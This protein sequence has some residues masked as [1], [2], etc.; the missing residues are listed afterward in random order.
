MHRRNKKVILDKTRGI[1]ILIQR[2]LVLLYYTN[3]PTKYKRLHNKIATKLNKNGER[4][5]QTYAR[6]IF[7]TSDVHFRCSH[8]KIKLVPCCV[9]LCDSV[10]IIV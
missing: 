6:L 2:R 4:H 9:E 5:Q 7:I 8:S 3:Q 1:I 10:E